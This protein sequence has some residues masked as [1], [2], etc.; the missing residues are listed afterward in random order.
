MPSQ[1]LFFFFK[2]WYLTLTLTD[3]LDF[4]TK[5]RFY[6]KEYIHVKYEDL[7]PTIQKL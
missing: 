1:R 3:D 7:S 5:E 6:R 2:T 4:V